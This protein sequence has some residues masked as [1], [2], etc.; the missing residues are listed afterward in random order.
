MMAM[1]LSELSALLDPIAVEMF[2]SS[3]WLQR[4]FH[5][6]GTPEK[7]GRIFSGPLSRR[8][9]VEG[10][11]ESEERRP[12]G[13]RLAAHA[14]PG[15]GADR[16]QDHR[17]YLIASRDIEREFASGRN[18]QGY[19]PAN[20]RVMRVAA[21][22]KSQLE[23]PGTCAVAMTL[24]PAG[25]GWPLHFDPVDTFIIQIEGT[26]RF[27]VSERPIVARPH[28]P[29]AFRADGSVYYDDSGNAWPD[30]EAI[31]VSALREVVLQPGDVFH[32]P[33]GVVH[34]S[35]AM[36]PSLTLFFDYQQ[37]STLDLLVDILRERLASDPAWREAPLAVPHPPGELAPEVREYFSARLGDL[38]DALEGIGHEEIAQRWFQAVAD[39]GDATQALMPGAET[40]GP[41]IELED[42]FIVGARQPVKWYLD[43]APDGNQRI[44]IL[45]RDETI[46]GE[47]EYFELLEKIAR[48]ASFS[49]DDARRWARELSWEQVKDTLST[50]VGHGVL[51]RQT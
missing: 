40:S 44:H 26:K 48:S 29:A 46:T 13:Y 2:R 42:R 35:K 19:Q 50:L 36:E 31:D 34:G 43:S 23:F 1:R 41:E 4:P 33:A 28:F 49:A 27:M 30:L 6:K 17:A 16:A 51:Q 5:I 25:F 22:L 7:I 47:D 21:Q 12:P 39:P 14:N 10:M 24:S 32:C 11:I 20:E 9:F 8:D 18:I 3:I 37:K 38:R 15:L 45:V